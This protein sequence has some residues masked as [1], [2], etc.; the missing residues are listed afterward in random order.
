MEY[1]IEVLKVLGFTAIGVAGFGIL[2][3]VVFVLVRTM[4]IGFYSGKDAVE[5]RRKQKE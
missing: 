5:K 3:L 1:I 2:M 4:T